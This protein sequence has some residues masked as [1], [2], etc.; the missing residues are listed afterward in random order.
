MRIRHRNKKIAD[1]GCCCVDKNRRNARVTCRPF[2]N[3][4]RNNENTW[5][6]MS[7]GDVGSG[8]PSSLLS[9]YSELRWQ[10]IPHLATA[11]DGE[12]HCRFPLLGVAMVINGRRWGQE[13]C[14]CL[15]ETSVHC[16]VCWLALK[17]V[18]IL[19]RW[20]I[21]ESDSL[22]YWRLQCSLRLPACMH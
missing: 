12:Y 20:W 8:F 15:S 3:K 5:D 6:V 1:C 10:R 21:F 16:S 2:S 7:L 11:T 18:V 22:N 13:C 4:R 9:V 17:P 14:V 19:E